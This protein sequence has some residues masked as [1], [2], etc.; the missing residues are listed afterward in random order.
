ARPSATVE[1]LQAAINWLVSH[2][3]AEGAFTGFSGEADPGT[4]S[5]AVLALAA[6]GNAGIDVTAPLADARDYLL[7]QSEEYASMGPGQAAK[8][9]LALYAAG[10]ELSSLD[11]LDLTTTS[12]A[13]GLYGTG[14]FDHALVILALVAMRE[15]VPAGAIETLRATRIEDGSWAYDGA[16]TLGSG[17]S[18]TTALVV[19]ALVGAG[20]V[21][22][23]MIAG[24]FTYFAETQS[25]ERGFAF[26]AAEPLVGDANSTAIVLQAAI[27]AGEDLDAPE[28]RAASQALRQFQNQS[29]AFRYNE[30]QLE[31]NLFATM[32]AI[33]ALAGEILPIS[34]V[35]SLATPGA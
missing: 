31:D 27:A 6:A 30:V 29:G 33:P 11:G 22:D 24:A 32:Q 18:N 5:D 2:Q 7:T 1:D 8:L 35:L 26:N 16:T 15:E 12:Q 19:Q 4:T 14:V 21:D 23:P 10:D 28:W 25:A 20:M 13:S 17:D 34:R 3:A 9:I